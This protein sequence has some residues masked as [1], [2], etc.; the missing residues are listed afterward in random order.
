MKRGAVP[1]YVQHLGVNRSTGS[2]RPKV[3]PEYISAVGVDVF[4]RG[5]PNEFFTGI[6]VQHASRRVCINNATR[7]QIDDDQPIGGSIENTKG[8]TFFFP[9]QWNFLSIFHENSQLPDLPLNHARLPGRFSNYIQ[10]SEVDNRR[11][12]KAPV[13]P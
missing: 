12:S 3:I 1:A 5:K 7:F 10:I 2:K 11:Y 8:S 4:R 13:L 9:R 6:A